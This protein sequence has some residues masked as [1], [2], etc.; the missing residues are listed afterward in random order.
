MILKTVSFYVPV[1]VSLKNQKVA[2]PQFLDS[3][4]VSLANSIQVPELNQFTL[5]FEA[6]AN[7]SNNYEW[8]AFSYGDS[9]MEFFSFGKTKQ[10][11]FIFISDSKCFL[12]DA[13]DISP[14]EDIFTETF[15]ELC[16]VWDSSL[17]IV[18]VNIKEMYKTVSCL[19]TYGKVIPDN[20]K[21]VLSSDKEDISPLP[22][23]MYNFRLWNFTMNSQSLF[24][25][26]CDEKGNIIDWENDFWS[27]PATFLKAENNL[28]C[29]EFLFL[30]L[31]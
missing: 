2:I 10:G 11:Y 6:R 5:C 8:K 22:G 28:S 21:L 29:G 20:G 3:D 16:I 1:A 9:S 23:D 4:S 17:G 7:N 27:I 24:N 15:E 30:N 31:V 18:G 25:L 13:L 12:N 26:T 14:N 19:D